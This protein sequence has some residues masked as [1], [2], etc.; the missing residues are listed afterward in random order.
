MEDPVVTC[1]DV[2]RRKFPTYNDIL[3][4]IRRKSVLHRSLECLFNTISTKLWKCLGLW[5]ITS[6]TLPPN[7]AW[8]TNKW[9][10]NNLV[11]GNQ[12]KLMFVVSNVDLSSYYWTIGDFTSMPYI[13]TNI[14]FYKFFQLI[15]THSYHR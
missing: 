5:T 4:L 11:A 6:A 12:T 8:K 14:T 7:G 2:S 1:I 13:F 9:H 10:N 15:T 3:V